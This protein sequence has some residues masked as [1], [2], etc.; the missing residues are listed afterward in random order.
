MLV[1]R[2]PGP[3]TMTSAS[4]DRADGVLGHDDVVGASQTRSM[5]DARAMR[6]WP[7]IV[8]PSLRRAW[9][10]TGVGRDRQDLAADRQHPV[11]LADAFLEV[12]ALD[13]R[14]GRDQ[15]VPDGVAG[16]ARGL[17]EL[18]GPLA[19]REAVLEQLGHERLGVGEGDDAVADVADGRHAELLA[20]LARRAAVVG[21]RDD[22]R[23][24][25]RVLLE[26]A[27][28]HRQAGP[29][30]DGHDL[31][32]AGEEALLVDDLDERLVGVRRAE[33]L[34]DRLDRLDR[35]EDEQPDPERAD[36]ER[37]RDIR[38]GAGG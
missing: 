2:L 8:S 14:Q 38:A 32:P 21:D 28:E 31:R 35:A 18:P 15:Q 27:Q 13:R 26:P 24:V 33:R 4:C 12:A 16:Q 7:S 10:T 6:D 22:R 3:R 17:V 30:A 11:H 1:K 29:A 5:P 34:H 20:E 37:P 19:L 25:A 9:R 23:E 36:D